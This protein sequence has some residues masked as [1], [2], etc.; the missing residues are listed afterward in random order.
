[1][2]AM[3]ERPRAPIAS[4]VLLAAASALAFGVTTPIV[5]HLGGGPRPLTTAALLYAGAALI[6]LALRP[7][8]KRSGSPL[9]R[10]V[11]P[12][13]LV[14]GV[15]GAALA[16]FLLVMGLARA[17]ATGTSLV[18]N[19]EA[20]FTVLLAWLMYREPIGV[21]VVWA[22]LAMTLGGALV[23]FD[24][25]ERLEAG[26]ALGLL[27]ILGATLCWALDNTLTRG[28]SHVDSLAVVAAKG[29][30]GAAITGCLALA[31]REPWPSSAQALGLL[32]CG[33][34][35]YGLSLR[36]YLSAQ[37]RMGAARTASVF[38]VG[39][40]IGAGLGWLLGDHGAGFGT[41]LGALAFGIGVYLHATE[42]HSHRHL[43]TA[44]DHEH[45]H[46]H[47]D[48]HHGH[49]HDPPVLGEHT[50]AHHHDRIEHDHEHAPDIDHEHAH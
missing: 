32:L 14:I 48:G 28:L 15:V 9:T 33:A 35:G 50:H 29:G 13:L 39:P 34:T 25:S 21:R 12:R 16:P 23:L 26:A 45:P 41:A 40:F 3:S 11:V 42:R 20:L 44:T 24:G 6:S 2:D 22:L 18:L 46:R 10:D 47:D 49:V 36:L 1:M 4:A 17:G 37:R 5:A 43:H 27:A 19:F 31:F 38:A 7:F 8:G 30:L